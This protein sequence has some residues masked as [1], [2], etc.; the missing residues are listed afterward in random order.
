MPNQAKISPNTRAL[1]FFLR[2]YHNPLDI[3]PR[4]NGLK[5]Y[6]FIRHDK[7]TTQDGKLVEPHYHVVLCF[8]NQHTVNSICNT[9]EKVADISQ[10]DYNFHLI[11]TT[12]IPGGVAEAYDYLTH[13]RDS[14]KFQYSHDLVTESSSIYFQERKADS[15]NVAS[16]EEA[17]ESFLI[18]LI[19]LPPIAMA[20]R[21]GKD[22]IKNFRSYDGFRGLIFG[23]YCIKYNLDPRT[24]SQRTELLH[25]IITDLGEL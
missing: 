16:R 1:N 14:E 5:E 20:K 13:S 9:I 24:P 17:N 8:A 10:T 19:A 2:T 11:P 23:E 18:D 15:N 3:I 6:A 21:Y 7:D 12:V 25:K 4:L 22:Y